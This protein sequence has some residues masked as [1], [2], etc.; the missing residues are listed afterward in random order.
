MSPIWDDGGAT[1]LTKFEWLL[2]TVNP[3][4]K[5]AATTSW[6]QRSVL[7]PNPP[8]GTTLYG[9]VV[10]Y[11]SFGPGTPSQVVTINM[12]PS[13]PAGVTASVRSNGILLR[14]TKVT[15]ANFESVEVWR[16]TT[17][18]VATAT[19]IGHGNRSRYFD[20]DEDLIDATTYFYWLR[21][22]DNTDPGN[23]GDYH[24]GNT[25]GTRAVT[26]TV[27]GYARAGGATPFPASVTNMGAITVDTVGNHIEVFSRDLGNDV[28]W[29]QASLAGKLVTSPVEKFVGT[30]S[31]YRAAFDG[32][33]TQ[34]LLHD[35]ALNQIMWGRISGAGTVLD[36]A[37]A[38]FTAQDHMGTAFDKAN[39]DG[40]FVFWLD[41]FG[42]NPL[43]KIAKLSKTG[44]I[45]LTETV[46]YTGSGYQLHYAAVQGSVDSEGNVHMIWDRSDLV[47]EPVYFKVSPAGALL[48]GPLALA[49]DVTNHIPV[50]IFV[51]AHD[52]VFVVTRQLPGD[53][54][55]ETYYKIGRLSKA[56]VV[57]AQPALI[58][59][60]DDA[61]WAELAHDARNDRFFLMRSNGVQD[62][63]LDVFSKV[64]A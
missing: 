64:N 35:T 8:A 58:M 41:S 52:T 7:I 1:D 25:A 28:W 37:V 53:V 40:T 16:S 39:N 22:R 23:V 55:D 62:L 45:T 11:D 42:A 31:F 51:D 19:L 57:K 50:G 59:T 26:S 21:V 63:K 15:D 24:T 34:L 14:Y 5:V 3:P 20:T 9:R 13:T 17:N 29:A 18:D 61:S 32:A 44:A 2:D 4:V 33:N 43:L 6:K 60:D 12:K 46:F 36:G 10:P 27:L 47:S 30:Y 38:K 54:V 48:V 49:G 56:G